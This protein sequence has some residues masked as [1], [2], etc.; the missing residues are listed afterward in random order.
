MWLL[1]S[2]MLGMAIWHLVALLPQRFWGSIVGALMAAIGGAAMFGLLV[3]GMISA[4]PTGSADQVLVGITG[5]LLGLLASNAVRKR[6][7]NRR[8]GT[9]QRANQPELVR[10]RRPRH[11]IAPV[12]HRDAPLAR[13]ARDLLPPRR[14]T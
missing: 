2:S 12:A 1:I 7:D 3:N 4:G 10:P 8:P 5:A 9:A 14:P 6:I 11:R 13:R